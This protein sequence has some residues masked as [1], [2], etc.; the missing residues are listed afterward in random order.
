MNELTGW[1]FILQSMK[2]QQYNH[3]SMIHWRVNGGFVNC[4]CDSVI[5]VDASH[6]TM[7]SMLAKIRPLVP[8][9]FKYL[10]SRDMDGFNQ[11][12]ELVEKF[13]SELEALEK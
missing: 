7:R 8:P 9:N 6:I 12:I 2:K 13:I 10:F 5:C 4:L 1:K 11:R 3:C